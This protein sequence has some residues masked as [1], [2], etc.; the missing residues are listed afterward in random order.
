MTTTHTPPAEGATIVFD[1][2]C[3]V[4]RLP[5]EEGGTM[6]MQ[7]AQLADNDPRPYY[8]VT[9]QGADGSTRIVSRGRA[10]A[11]EFHGSEESAER[12]SA[13]R[14]PHQGEAGASCCTLG[15]LGRL[16]QGT[17]AQTERTARRLSA[18][19]I[20]HICG[21]PTMRPPKK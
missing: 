7:I 14:L 9:E 6:R 4:L 5:T 17:D 15:A 11:T 12:D 19:R 8:I 20:G 1:G 3:A 13:H 21:L 16:L 18:A 2:E 10:E